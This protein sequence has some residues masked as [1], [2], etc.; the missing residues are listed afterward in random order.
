[1]V[2]SLIKIQ[3]LMAESRFVEAQRLIEGHLIDKN[4]MGSIEL[5]SVYFECLISQQKKIPDEL[6]L[7]HVD[8]IIEKDLDSA[9]RWIGFIDQSNK[10]NKQSII[11]LQTR[12]AE[13][14]GL[15]KKLYELIDEL[16]K[17]RIQNY[18]TEIPKRI[19]EFIEK[20]FPNDLNIKLLLVSVDLLSLNLVSSEE[21]IKELIISCYESSSRRGI[22]EKLKKIEK[23]LSSA[24]KTYHLEIYKSLLSLMING[25]KE[26]KDFKRLI[27]VVIYFED[28]K[29]QIIILHLLDQLSLENITSN[30]SLEIKKNKEFTLVYVSKYF[31]ELKKYFVPQRTTKKTQNEITEMTIDLS[32]EESNNRIAKEDKAHIISPDERMVPHLVEIQNYSIDQLLDLSVSLYQSEYYFASAEVAQLALNNSENNRDM[33]KSKYLKITSLF[34]LQDY[35][36][37]VDESL[38]ALKTA[39][40]QNDILS[41]LYTMAEAHIR[42]GENRS[43]IG[44]LKKIIHIDGQYR[45]AKMKLEE[46]DAI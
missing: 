42:L 18:Q 37:I 26:K 20:F 43:A 21:K 24:G 4:K 30:Y 46:L 15:N 14:Q 12:I 33:L 28:V 16:L 3:Q 6:L 7:N 13:K 45:L 31:P 36:A 35:R 40:T 11:F 8:K 10:K 17:H 29:L 27:E 22:T 19:N 32:L 9:Q 23:L 25:F 38:E 1:M 44:I 2:E 5:I 39:E 41:F 34:H